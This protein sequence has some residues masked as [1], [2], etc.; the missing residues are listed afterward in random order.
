MEEKSEGKVLLELFGVAGTDRRVR[1]R[2]K[3]I[4]AT[5]KTG[6]IKIAE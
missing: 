5:R 3:G 4:G 2:W 6:K 1:W